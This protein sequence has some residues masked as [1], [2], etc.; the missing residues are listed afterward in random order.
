MSEDDA[1]EIAKKGGES[2][3]DENAASRKIGS[4]PR[5]PAVRAASLEETETAKATIRAERR[6]G[7]D[8]GSS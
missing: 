5:R 1:R 8:E 4:L 3:L 2:V 7:P 6:R